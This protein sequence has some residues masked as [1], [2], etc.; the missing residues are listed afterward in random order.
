MGSFLADLRFAARLLARRPALTLIAVITTA[1][2]IG[3]STAIFSVVDAVLL[4]ALPYR[5]ADR[6]VMVWESHAERNRPHNPINLGNFY[7]WRAQ[8]R[9]LTDFASIFDTTAALG[10][11]GEPEQV[12]IQYATPELFRV[13]GTSPLMGRTFAPDDGVEGQPNSVVLSFGLWQRRFGGDGSIIG[14][15]FLMNGRDA[16]VVGVMPEGFGFHIKEGSMTRQPAQLW[17]A[18][19]VEEELKLRRGRFAMAVARV[20]PGATVPAAHAEMSAIGA[21]LAREY[22][23]F[24]AGWGV[25]V[26]SLR[27]QLSGD[28]RPSLLVLMG[29]VGLLLLIACANVSNLVLA[30]ATARHHEIAVRV[31]LGARRR[32]I[33]RQ[34][35]T[36]SV[37]LAGIGGLAGLG[38][39]AWG[40][41]A[42]VAL[43]PP[44]LGSL[45]DI[46]VNGPVLAFALAISLATGIGFGLAPAVVATRVDLHES[47]KEG[48][49]DSGG[50]RRRRLRGALVV[51][52][53]ALA[54]ILLVGAGLTMKS[55]LN[56]SAVH[57]G[58]DASGVLTMK[59]SL[60]SARYE[61]DESVLAT[62]R[63]ATEGLAALP[64]VETVGAVSYLPFAGPAA[65]TGVDVVGRPPLPPGSGLVTQ[66]DVVD[67]GFFR[68]LRIPLVRG[69]LFSADEERSARHVVVVNQTFARTIFP[70]EDPVGKRV[71]IYMKD[72]NLPSTIIGV[73][74]DSMHAT[75]DGAIEP[76]AYWPHPELVYSSMTFVLRASG[77][78]AELAGAARR[79]IYAI[80]PA[81]P[82]ADVQ[83]LD[84]LLSRSIAR[85]RFTSVLLA[86]FAAVAL[87]LAAVGIGGVM[88]VSVAQRTREIGIRIA[89]GA[90]PPSV[91]GLVVREGMALA[92][93]GLAIG[94]VGALA[95]ARFLDKLLF[96]VA[97]TDPLIYLLIA[98]GLAASALI[99]CLIPARRAA[100]VDPIVALRHE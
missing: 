69:R 39:A 92:L 22:P 97:P 57:P 90:P 83:T 94:V 89:I 27:A 17:S 37:L 23:D 52:E 3:A 6:L 50:V 43:A 34:L 16:V 82:V 80:D 30:R 45:P 47:L 42:L 46:A 64:G 68:A 9:T 86:V 5:D 21:R 1:L 61:T 93:T 77:D 96:G 7:D 2:G 18:W 26:V 53:T 36:E 67:S 91:I 19:Q 78:P 13:L 66:V 55:F 65:G 100:R 41:D 14:R 84:S 4:R 31:A 8:S 88:A 63:R 75:L 15:R 73:V 62:V 49:R 32:R 48:A 25:N 29:A 38:L 74:A 28:L 44:E 72:E 20:A 11:D 51:I 71:I 58:F 12:P 60:P 95:L 87:L 54:L 98:A 40:I 24:N 76:M 85:A 81:Q 33:V 35:L 10:G 56:L 59:V 79:V 70:G 99:A